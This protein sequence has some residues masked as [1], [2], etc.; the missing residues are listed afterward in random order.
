M[1]L[2]E[3]DGEMGV[4][5]EE[6]YG[7]VDGWVKGYMEGGFRKVWVCLGC[8]G[9]EEGWVYWGEEVGEEVKKKL[10]VEVKVIEREEKIEENFRG[11]E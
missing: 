10:G 6:V 3:E 7:V 5:V 4:L 1:G 2:V 8:R 11:K 9:G